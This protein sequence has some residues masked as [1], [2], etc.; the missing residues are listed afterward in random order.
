MTRA[1]LLVAAVAALLTIPAVATAVVPPK[2]CGTMSV[3][4]KRYQ[5]K[6]DQ[7]SCRSGRE[8][9]RRFIRSARKPRGYRC[10]DYPSKKGRVDFYCNNGRKIF[11]AI[12]R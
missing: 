9:A 4:G 11:F 10:K 3:S 5:V 2:N 8:Y 12:R 1:V 6:A 7:I